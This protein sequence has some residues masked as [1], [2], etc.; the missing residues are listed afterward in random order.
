[1]KRECIAIRFKKHN[2]YNRNAL[3]TV[4][5]ESFE[6]TTTGYVAINYFDGGY[7]CAHKAEDIVAVY[8]AKRESMFKDVETLE[9]HMNNYPDIYN[10]TYDI[11]EDM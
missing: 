1:M 4:Y 10:P 11:P 7:N 8:I 6:I 2:S 9:Y 3:T 5:A